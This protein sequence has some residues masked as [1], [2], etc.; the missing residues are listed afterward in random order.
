MLTIENPTT[1]LT[2]ATCVASVA[3]TMKANAGL[4]WNGFAGA[5][6]RRPSG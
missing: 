2:D 3:H 1:F 5:F 4:V 6:A